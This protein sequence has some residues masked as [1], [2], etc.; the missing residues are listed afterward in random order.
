MSK[1]MDRTGFFA[2]VLTFVG[3]GAIGIYALRY[4]SRRARRLN[5]EARRRGWDVSGETSAMADRILRESFPQVTDEKNAEHAI[6]N[7]ASLVH[8]AA[9]V[10]VY[11]F[12]L[13]R[14]SGDSGTSTWHT[15]YLIDGSGNLPSLTI[16]R[17]LLVEQLSGKKTPVGSEEFR[18]KFLLD[19]SDSAPPEFM[20]R[21]EVE[22]ILLDDY[23][24]KLVI[25]HVYARG[26]RLLLETQRAEPGGEVDASLDMAFRLYAALRQ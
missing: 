17:R 7:A 10:H 26:R 11:D 19:F 22:R 18:S 14:G 21:P 5:E 12:E 3:F 24:G 20:L 16:V 4:N 15:H 23:N 25:Q 8:D 13:H 9:K 2:M 1:R 6:R